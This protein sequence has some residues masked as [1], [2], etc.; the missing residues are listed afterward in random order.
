VSGT[1]ERRGDEGGTAGSLG[2]G[3]GAG[4]GVAD[5]EAGGR[6][7]PRSTGATVGLAASAGVEAG[8]GGAGG[9][10]SCACARLGRSTEA[11]LAKAKKN[12]R[13][14]ADHGCRVGIV[15]GLY[16]GSFAFCELH[17]VR[18]RLLVTTR[19]VQ[20]RSEKESATASVTDGCCTIDTTARSASVA[21]G[22]GTKSADIVAFS[23]LAP[24]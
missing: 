2:A 23:T 17:F 13:R 21:G 6:R 1:G 3:W 16:H 14:W 8:G 9:P 4:C 24:H 10:A 12:A 20:A 5:G 15:G 19:A 11:K 7:G 22:G 18:G